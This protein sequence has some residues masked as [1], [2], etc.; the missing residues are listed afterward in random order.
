MQK[1]KL[2]PGRK[3]I[4]RTHTTREGAER[5]CGFFMEEVRAKLPSL[6]ECLK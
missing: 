6:A 5:C 2:E 4:Y 3:C 1:V